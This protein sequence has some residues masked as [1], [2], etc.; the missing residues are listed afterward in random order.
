MGS[1]IN[2]NS[3]SSASSGANVGGLVSG[4]VQAPANDV[5]QKTEVPQVEQAVSG[6]E[7]KLSKEEAEQAAAELK[8]SLNTFSGTKVSFDVSVTEDEANGVQ[9][10]VVDADS[11]EVVRKFPQ[12][13]IFS[14]AHK[15]GSGMLI[16]K[17]A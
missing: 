11:G 6:F 8:K 1:D 10:Q 13:S 17:V 15:G 14:S 5:P 2:I 4:R 7:K 3:L 16:K 9:F 12:E